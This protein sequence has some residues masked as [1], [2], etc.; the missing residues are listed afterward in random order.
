MFCGRSP[1]V[2]KEWYN[3][4]KEENVPEENDSGC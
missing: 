4:E 1:K 3:R 2:F